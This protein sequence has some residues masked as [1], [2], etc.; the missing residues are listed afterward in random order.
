MQFTARQLAK[1]S[2]KAEKDAAKEKKK[3][4]AVRMACNCSA[5]PPDLFASPRPVAGDRKGQQGGC[6]DLRGEYH[7]QKE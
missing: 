7:P 4:K 6:P 5:P 3:I 1:Q 2:Q